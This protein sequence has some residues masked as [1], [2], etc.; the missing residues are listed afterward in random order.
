MNQ[1]CL[2]ST[3]PGSLVNCCA[4]QDELNIFNLTSVLILKDSVRPSRSP[5]LRYLRVWRHNKKVLVNSVHNDIQK[6]LCHF[7]IRSCTISSPD[8]IASRHCLIDPSSLILSGNTVYIT[9]TSDYACSSS[10]A[11]PARRL[12][13]TEHFV[14]LQ[15]RHCALTKQCYRTIPPNVSHNG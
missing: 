6:Q 10:L 12:A 4:I 5:L 7:R 9:S 13:V 14:Y 2:C 1:Q 8:V 3:H 11:W 15:S